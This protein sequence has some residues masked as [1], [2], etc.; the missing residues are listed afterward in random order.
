V[1]ADEH[2]GSGEGTSVTAS[3]RE[4]VDRIAAIAAE[5]DDMAFDDLRE[6]VA[7]G[8]VTRPTSDRRLM[9]A[10]RALEKAMVVLGQIDEDQAT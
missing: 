3:H 7:E 10:R 2:I 9:Q 6:A 1:A 4:L 5:I 8:A